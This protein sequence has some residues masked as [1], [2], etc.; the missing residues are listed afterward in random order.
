MLVFKLW[1][2]NVTSMMNDTDHADIA[3]RPPII[4]V[5]SILVGIIANRYW[6]GSFSIVRSVEVTAGTLLIVSSVAIVG[7]SLVAFIRAGQNPDPT[8]PTQSLYTG[9]PY[10]I[11]RNPMYVAMA[12]FQIGLAFC[13]DNIWVATA[14]IASVIAIHFGVVLQEE[15]YLSQ[16]FGDTYET[17]R[18]CVRRYL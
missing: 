6:P 13:L 15:S 16:K 9:G 1:S 7:W 14:T 5:F 8:A 17:Y 18:S 4:I 12:I 2:D 3:V 11:S 10:A